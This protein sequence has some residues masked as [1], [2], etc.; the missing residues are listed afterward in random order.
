MQ[1]CLM[2]VVRLHSSHDCGSFYGG[3]AK[4]CFFALSDSEGGAWCMDTWLMMVP[5]HHP[6]DCDSNGTIDLF[7]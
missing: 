6:R 7:F 1:I 2:M 5:L 4:L 3:I